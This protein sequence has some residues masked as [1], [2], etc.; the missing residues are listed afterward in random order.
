MA[1]IL[2]EMTC[3]S[4]IIEGTFTFTYKMVFGIFI[5]DKILSSEWAIISLIS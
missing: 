1:G 4:N 5:K 3:D 2:K